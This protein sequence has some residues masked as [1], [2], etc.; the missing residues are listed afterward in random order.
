MQDGHPVG[1]VF[2]GVACPE[3]GFRRV[4][5]LALRGTRQE[6]RDQAAERALELLDRTLGMNSGGVVV[7]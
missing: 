7:E 6:I 2:V 4:E 3:A 5:E 1:Q